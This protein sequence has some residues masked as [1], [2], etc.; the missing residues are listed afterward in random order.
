MLVLNIVLNILIFCLI[1]VGQFASWLY[2]LI[3]L[4]IVACICIFYFN[5]GM[6]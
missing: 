3:N 4:M 2:W 6:S 5:D 1:I